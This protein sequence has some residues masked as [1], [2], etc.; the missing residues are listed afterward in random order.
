MRRVL[1]LVALVLFPAAAQAQTGLLS[2]LFVGGAWQSSS[3]SG[4]SGGT[5]G[6]T[7]TSDLES[8]SG[9]LV[10]G[11]WQLSSL[12][13][14]V[15]RVSS[16]N[17]DRA[18]AAAD[19]TTIK[20]SEILARVVLPFSL[21]RLTPF[22]E[23]GL[24][25]RDFDAKTAGV[26]TITASGNT[27]IFGAGVRVRLATGIQAEAAYH[28][29]SSDFKTWTLNGGASIGDDPIKAGTSRITVGVVVHPVALLRR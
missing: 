21:S 17:F 11:G 14:V 23:A 25:L 27:P 24:A 19:K 5:G 3:L 6:N 9:V 22:V 1:S 16:T 28:N 2:G 4:G 13:G 15:G 12:L 29:V 26:A 18:G 8:G 10:V 7:L 20:Q